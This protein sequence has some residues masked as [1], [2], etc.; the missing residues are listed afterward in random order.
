M[1]AGSSVHRILQARILEWVA[2]SSSRGSFP[3]QGSNPCLLHY[4]QRLFFVLFFS[5]FKLILY[6]SI[7]DWKCCGSFRW[8]A[9]GLRQTYVCLFSL[10]SHS[11]PGWRV[12]LSRVPCAGSCWLSILNIAVCTWPSQTP[13]HFPLATIS[14]FSKSAS[15]CF[16]S[17]FICIISFQIPH[18]RG[19]MPY[20]S[21]CVWLFD[22]V[23]HCIGPS[24]DCKWHYFILF[25][26]WVIFHC[27]YVPHLL[28][29]VFCQGTFRLLLMDI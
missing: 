23:W 9:K 19:V 7:A 5:N 8:T 16:V 15:L 29:P 2:I 18:I 24:I 3:T 22:S 10:K 4:R 14:S 27:V 28:Y 13:Y 6:W 17:K 25:N 12:T 11:H 1:H 21:Y 26:V 20:F